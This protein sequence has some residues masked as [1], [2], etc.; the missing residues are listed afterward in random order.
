MKI[1]IQNRQTGKTYDIVQRIKAEKDSIMVV[2]NLQYRDE[3][4]RTYK[5]SKERQV[6]LYGKLSGRK[7]KVYVDELG[8]C[9]DLMIPRIE[10]ATHTDA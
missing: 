10:Y 9:L 2:P 5:I 4:C 3:V 1:K 6:I 8:L 7:G